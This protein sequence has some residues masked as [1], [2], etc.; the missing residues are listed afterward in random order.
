MSPGTNTA[1]RRRRCCPPPPSPPPPPPPPPLRKAARRF[2][3]E[4]MKSFGL[5]AHVGE[6]EIMLVCVVVVLSF[7]F[8]RCSCSRMVRTVL[9]ERCCVRLQQ[10]SSSHLDPIIGA[11]CGHVY[12]NPVT[13]HR[14]VHARGQGFER[15][16]PFRSFQAAVGR[17]ERRKASPDCS[18]PT[19]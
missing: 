12:S 19:A 15:G 6:G 4:Y 11:G 9:V 13:E 8:S 5:G 10:Y 14:H 1:C 17:P 18:Q 3:G 16:T 2:L 7:F